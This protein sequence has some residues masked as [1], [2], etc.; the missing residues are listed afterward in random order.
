MESPVNTASTPPT[1]PIVCDMT[2]APDTPGERI[3]EYQRLF[4]GSLTGRERAGGTIRFRFRSEQGLEESVRDLAAREKAC[5]PF[6]NFT[7]TRHG[8]ELWWEAS[9]ID[10]DIARQILDEFYLLPDTV[11]GGVQAV[12]D[13]FTGQGLRVLTGDSGTHRPAT[14]KDPGQADASKCE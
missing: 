13:R 5:C 9:V 7:I 1:P 4:S 2:G 8:E 12:G 10:D 11:P 14:S 6:F 3:A